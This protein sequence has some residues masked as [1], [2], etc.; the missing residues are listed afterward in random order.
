LQEVIKT[1]SEFKESRNIAEGNLLW[2]CGILKD[3]DYKILNNRDC[4]YNKY[5][6]GHIFA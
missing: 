4:I 3:L 1:T 2:Y 6:K 5:P